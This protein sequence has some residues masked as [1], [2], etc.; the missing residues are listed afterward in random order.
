MARKR[1]LNA[2]DIFVLLALLFALL[3]VLGRMFMIDQFLSDQSALTKKET[4]VISF[5]ASGVPLSA[6]D[7][8]AVGAEVKLED[9]TLL[10]TVNDGASITPAET[11]VLNENFE[12]VLVYSME[13]SETGLRDVRGTITIEAESKEG[14][15]VFFNGKMHLAA[16]KELSVL[17]PNVTADLLITD[18]EKAS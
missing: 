10:G 6:T 9:G 18:I 16:G 3:G 17:L 5:L 1:K 13:E 8:F 14:E 4:Y 15:G 11:Y 12:Y 2:A 7:G